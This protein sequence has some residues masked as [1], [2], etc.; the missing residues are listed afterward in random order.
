M[1]GTHQFM[2]R[3]DYQ[4]SHRDFSGGAKMVKTGANSGH[5]TWLKIQAISSGRSPATSGIFQP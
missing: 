4:K 2:N 1:G 5:Q 3:F